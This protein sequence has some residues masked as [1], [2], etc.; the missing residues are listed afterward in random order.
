MSQ[1]AIVVQGFVRPDGTQQLDEKLS[2]PAARVQVIV[3]PLPDLSSDPVWQRMEAIW[4]GHAARG[5]VPRRAED[6]ELERR[7]FREEIEGE[8]Q[9]A[10]R[11][12]EESRRG[13]E[14]A[15]SGQAPAASS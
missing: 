4:A 12:Q 9:E 14:Q 15:H 8:I 5:H 3:Q 10:M 13:R 6:V 1:T 7:A 11:I 2:V